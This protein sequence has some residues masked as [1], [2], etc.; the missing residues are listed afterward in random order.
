[1]ELIS[2]FISFIILSLAPAFQ[3]I[4]TQMRIN[5]KTGLSILSIFLISLIIGIICSLTSGYIISLNTYRSV[6]DKTPLLFLS[7]G[8]L[9]SF[10]G[11]T[12]IGISGMYRYKKRK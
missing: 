3:V 7:L 1:M 9:I 4:F 8:L 6:S 5:G 11:S 2:I 12:I 10:I